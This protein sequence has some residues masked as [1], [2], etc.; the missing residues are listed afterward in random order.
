MKRQ[1]LGDSK[2][3]FKWDYH[4]ALATALGFSALEVLPMLTADDA[5]GHGATATSLYP[6]RAEILDLCRELRASRDMGLVTGMPRR[7]GGEYV[8][9][10][11]QPD[12]YFS[13]AQRGDY[14]A[15]LPTGPGL[16]VFADPD[17]GFEPAKSRSER[18]LAY[19]DVDN[20]LGQL[21]ARSLLSVFHHFRRVR[22]SED[23][24]RIRSRLAAYATTAVCWHSVMFVAVSA[25][26]PMINTVRRFNRE[27]ALGRPV[28]TI[29]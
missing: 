29:A 13:C 17:N 21:P 7:T 20:I 18:H 8:V 2:D 26:A 27:Y 14:F 12:R 10:L 3:S 6:A 24:A 4:D 16:L 1:F 23:F 9:G 5:G 28:R 25:S 19:T 22:F 11:H 15:G